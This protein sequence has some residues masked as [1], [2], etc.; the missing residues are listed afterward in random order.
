MG[1]LYDF[2]YLQLKVS[3]NV[4][5]RKINSIDT[6]NDRFNADIL[7]EASWREPRLDVDSHEVHVHAV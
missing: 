4:A 5:F 3:I 2:V 7:V 6:S 1:D